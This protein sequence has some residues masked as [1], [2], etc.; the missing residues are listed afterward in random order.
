MEVDQHELRS[1]RLWR[2]LFQGKPLKKQI[3]VAGL[4]RAVEVSSLAASRV[5]TR[6]RSRSPLNLKQLRMHS[7]L[8]IQV[9]NST[10]DLIYLW[11]FHVNL[12][13]CLCISQPDCCGR[14]AWRHRLPSWS[15]ILKGLCV[16]CCF[17]PVSNSGG[18][19]CMGRYLLHMWWVP[20]FTDPRNSPE[21]VATMVGATLAQDHRLPSLKARA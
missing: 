3:F 12:I 13:Q 8:C 15:L 6:S 2:C 1:E 18:V 5:S 10:L 11:L 7:K 16:G 19:C 17:A 20:C 21:K 9:A 4:L 14:K